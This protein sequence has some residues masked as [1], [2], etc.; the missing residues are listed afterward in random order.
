MKSVTLSAPSYQELR[1][2]F[3]VR[4]L[5]VPPDTDLSFTQYMELCKRFSKGYDKLKDRDTTKDIMR[6]VN[7]YIGEL[8]STGINDH[9][10]KNIRFTY[11]WIVRK[12]FWTFVLFHIYLTLC[13]P[14]IIILSPIGL[15]IRRKA[16]KERIAVILYY[17]QCLYIS[18]LKQKIQIKLK[19]WML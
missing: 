16:E 12:S 2:L 1:S 5:Y 10:V 18:R 7:N 11:V 14:A 3:F 4:K 8:E 13:L 9:E 17:L 15:L 6:K 19:L